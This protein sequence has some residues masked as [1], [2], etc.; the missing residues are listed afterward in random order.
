MGELT[1]GFFIWYGTLDENPILNEHVKYISDNLDYNDLLKLTLLTWHFDASEFLS[2]G[3]LHLFDQPPTEFEKLCVTLS[4][5][6][7]SRT[8]PNMAPYV[9]EQELKELLFSTVFNFWYRYLTSLNL[10][11]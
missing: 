5:Q 9:F 10:M 8:R 7:N 4:D 6:Y 2:P 3:L 11:F 1:I